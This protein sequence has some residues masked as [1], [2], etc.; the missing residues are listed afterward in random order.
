MCKRFF[1]NL[2][3]VFLVFTIF[4]N[5]TV[6]KADAFGGA[7]TGLVLNVPSVGTAVVAAAPYVAAFAACCVALG[8]VWENKE[9][10]NSFFQNAYNYAKDKGQDLLD[11][12][13]S[14]STSVSIS[15]EGVSS[16]KNFIHEYTVDPSVVSNL[17][18]I[19]N[20]NINSG[21]FSEPFQASLSIPLEPNSTY[22]F[23]VTLN[24]PLWETDPNGSYSIDTHLFVNGIK[25][26]GVSYGLTKSNPSYN[27]YIKTSSDSIQYDFYRPDWSIGYLKTISGIDNFSFNVI[28]S[29]FSSTTG[30]IC[31]DRTLPPDITAGNFS[32]VNPTDVTFKNPAISGENGISIGIP[33]DLTWDK[34]VGTTWENTLDVSNS[35]DTDLPTDKPL[36]PSFDLPTDVKLDFSPLEISLKDRF[37]FCIPWDLVNSFRMFSSTL[38][39]PKFVVNFPKDYLIGGGSF[40]IDFG[41]FSEVAA[42]LRY[43]IL[44]IFVVELI[45]KTRSLIGG[46]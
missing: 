44:I 22:N 17:G 46:E 38:E 37:P 11:F 20:L 41:K 39:T 29:S 31:V 36:F 4:I 25:G 43:F 19:S 40:E 8:V 28:G 23:L 2:F 30:S 42:I 7:I 26:N 14:S 12:F 35:K 15:S 5:S 1:I 27:V 34:V 6:A 18:T 10:I 45:K 9:Q 32:G 16:I 13:S 3:C 33:T 21:T 24:I